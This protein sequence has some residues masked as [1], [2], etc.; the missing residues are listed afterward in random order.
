[1]EFFG[2]SWLETPQQTQKLSPSYTGMSLE[3]YS[4]AWYIQIFTAYFLVN[5]N[6]LNSVKYATIII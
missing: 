2:F 4:I 6:D 3:L 5:K 1:M